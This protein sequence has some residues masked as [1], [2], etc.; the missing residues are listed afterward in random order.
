MKHLSPVYLSETADDV[1]EKIPV[2]FGVL[3]VTFGLFH[4]AS[5]VSTRTVFHDHH[6]PRA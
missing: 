5:K 4:E 1:K 3:G 2:H 6:M